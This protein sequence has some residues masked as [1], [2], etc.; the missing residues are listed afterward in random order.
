MLDCTHGGV[1][2]D[3]TQCHKCAYEDCD[4][5]RIRQSLKSV[6]CDQGAEPK[7]FKNPAFQILAHMLDLGITSIHIH[8]PGFDFDGS[9]DPGTS[10]PKYRMN[11][12]SNDNAFLTLSVPLE[13]GVEPR[14]VCEAY[15]SAEEELGLLWLV[16]AYTSP[17]S[18]SPNARSNNQRSLASIR[19]PLT[20][21]LNRE[22]LMV[23]LSDATERVKEGRPFA[24]H[25]ID[26]DD[27]KTI[28]DTLGHQFGDSVLISIADTIAQTIAETDVLARF[29]GDEFC[30]I[31]FDISGR[32]DV[33]KTSASI[34]EAVSFI[35][36]INH[37]PIQ[38]TVSVG[39]TV[40]SKPGA[41][42]EQALSMADMA[43]YK[44]KHQGKN[45]SCIFD[46]R[47]GD[48]LKIQFEAELAIR[49]SSFQDQL[50]V[51]YQPIFDLQTQKVVR[52]EALVR[53]HQAEHFQI[54]IDRLIELS[55]NRS[56]Y[57]IIQ[58]TVLGFIIQ[59]LEDLRNSWNLS[60][61]ISLN[62]SP[63]EV[64]DFR[65]QDQFLKKLSSS[66]IPMDMVWLEITEQ[67]KIQLDDASIQRIGRLSA[68]GVC[69][70]LDDFGAGYASF[71]GLG[72]ILLKEIKIDKS[73]TRSV[74]TDSKNRKIV[75]GICKLAQELDLNVVA[76]GCETA[77]QVTVLK[78]IG[79]GQG[80]GYYYSRPVG[81]AAFR[82][83]VLDSSQNDRS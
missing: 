24:L 12:G 47:L 9:F 17:L 50:Y 6:L 54:S 3:E 43:M 77:E 20:N 23:A 49:S 67:Q 76:E 44:V 63:T 70:S 55:F 30:V 31:Q 51:V 2:V 26:V 73:L 25:L 11:L 81:A 37:Q 10:F 4:T 38:T 60:I 80:Q 48:A 68:K 66:T 5:F 61:P 27:F 56:A 46:Q 58:S 74:A 75:S 53:W 19:D 15:L 72:G 45:A 71:G 64:A 14:H 65:W 42:S 22:G 62:V 21:T 8:F 18:D 78:E 83:L 41:T 52:A 32:E 29:G 16:Q 34:A 79:C 40:V 36:E 82:Q 28:N 33:A 39:S 13:N 69:L 35:E 57:E 7:S 1:N 59:E